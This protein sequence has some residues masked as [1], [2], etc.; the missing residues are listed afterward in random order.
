[1][2]SLKMN[3][4]FVQ[5]IGNW[6]MAGGSWSRGAMQKTPTYCGR[7]LGMLQKRRLNYYLGLYTL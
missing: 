2:T 1:M 3:H 6:A 4:Q 5:L 7:F